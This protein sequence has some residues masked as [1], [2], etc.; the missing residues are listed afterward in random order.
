MGMEA[1]FE[2]SH[3]I[4][5][6]V[7]GRGT[8][9]LDLPRLLAVLAARQAAGGTVRLMR[10]DDPS[11]VPGDEPDRLTLIF[12][13]PAVSPAALQRAGGSFNTRVAACMATG[14]KGESE[15]YSGS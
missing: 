10:E 3:P 6:H 2:G 8:R 5:T 7:A 13:A 11:F 12:A 1:A 9:I 4:V 14:V 15:V